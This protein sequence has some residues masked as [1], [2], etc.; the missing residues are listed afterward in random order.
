MITADDFARD[1]HASRY[2]GELS[3]HA[4]AFHSL[5]GLLNDAANEQR[6]IDA[7][8][9]GLPALSGIVRFIEADPIIA[10]SLGD[11]SFTVRTRQT[12]GVAVKLKMAKLGWRTTGKKGVVRGSRHFAK[13]ERFI[14]PRPTPAETSQALAALDDVAAIGDDHERESTGQELMKALAASRRGERRPF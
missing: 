2:Q 5:F 3:R 8:M 6:L 10:R 14:G 4:E 11:G 1:S 13:A 12:V 9:H 7:E